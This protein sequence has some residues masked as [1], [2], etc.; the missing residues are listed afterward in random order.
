MVETMQRLFGLTRSDS[1]ISLHLLAGKTLREIS[2]LRGVSIHT[3]RNQIKSA[4]TKAGTNRQTDYVLRL[5]RE[6]PS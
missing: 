4:M 2:S 5:D 1:E 6:L 3:V